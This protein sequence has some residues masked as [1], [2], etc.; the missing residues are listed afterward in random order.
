MEISVD[1][2][3]SPAVLQWQAGSWLGI[4]LDIIGSGITFFVVALAITCDQY[5]SSVTG[6]DFISAGYLA[7]GLTYSFSLTQALKFC[8]RVMAQVEANM[9]SVERLKYYSEHVEQ[10]GIFLSDDEMKGRERSA[11][12]VPSNWPL[13]GKVESRNI[14]MRYRDGPLILKGLSF[15]VEA[16][17]KVGIAGRTGLVHYT[18]IY[19]VE[20]RYFTSYYKVRQE[21]LDECVI[22]H[23]RAGRRADADR[24]NRYQH[25]SLADSAFPHRHCATGSCAL[26]R[27]CAFQLGPL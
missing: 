4:R 8:V 23:P 25:H 22:P 6:D 21:Q 16:G 18:C 7:L 11:V 10:E 9:N 2:N 26:L 1:A 12:T 19:E 20:G 5:L 17:E 24:R 15:V 27:D 13:E 3:T 14:Q